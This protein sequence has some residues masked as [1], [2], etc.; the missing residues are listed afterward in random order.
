[1]VA[2][3]LRLGLMLAITATMVALAV[4]DL[5]HRKLPNSLLLVLALL[6]L[7]W[8]WHSDRALLTAVAEASVV[9][10]VAVLLNAGFRLVAGRSGLGMGDAK[11]LTAVAFALP[12]G[13]LL[14]FLAMAG[15][16]GL[17]LGLF[18]RGRTKAGDFPFGPAVAASAWS[19]LLWA[20]PAML[21]L[22]AH[23]PFACV[24]IKYTLSNTFAG[25]WYHSERGGSP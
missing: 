17:A 20:D 2:D 9:F 25:S 23:A 5:E 10:T 12:P 1:M 8:R 21:W 18:W 22:I 3:P 16:A 4:L 13:P 11:L 6:A 19:S 24:P 7:A 14:F 15:I